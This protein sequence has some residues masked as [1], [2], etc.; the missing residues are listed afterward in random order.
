M[1]VLAVMPAAAATGADADEITV[2]GSSRTDFLYLREPP[3]GLEGLLEDGSTN[4]D[5]WFDTRAFYRNWEGSVRLRVHETAGIRGESSTEEIDRR[6]LAYVGP[7]VEVL[8]GHFYQTL[9]NGL[10][11]RAMEQ[12]FVT[13]NHVDRAFNLDRSL[14][15]VRVRGERGPVR[16]TLLSGTPRR[17]EISRVGGAS[18]RESDDLLQG[19][20]AVVSAGNHVE[21]G[22]GYLMAEL[23][24][25]VGAELVRRPEDLVSYRGRVQWQGMTGE[26]EVAEKR[27]RRGFVPDGHA[28]VVRLNGALGFVGWSLEGKR[29]RDFAFLHNQPPTLVRTHES[30][31]LNRET[32][33]LLP[34]DER[35]LQAEVL[36]A[37]DVFT[38]F[39]V[40]VALAEGEDLPGRE[41]REVYTEARTEREGLGAGR[42][43]LDW[44]RDETKV[45][46]NRWTAALELETFLD[47]LNSVILDLELQAEETV[48][49]E[50][51]RQLLQLGV[52][53]A[54][55][56]TVTVTGEHTN[57]RSRPK[58]DWV[59][60][61]LDLRLSEM[62]D[63][64]VGYG[65]RP[66]GIVCSGGFCFE[67]PEF[68]GAEVR[69]L[70]RF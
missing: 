24:D 1:M 21:L 50:V 49:R 42:L 28:L 19:G 51:T 13:L 22:F 14:D 54:G 39:L 45:V 55:V 62:F 29:Y 48:S 61:S 23:A 41:Y 38:T 5:V 12:R 20:E 30:V 11:L 52:S 68:D 64:T 46:E 25:S 35:G 66:A 7:D 65:S 32:H 67:S 10:I 26:V 43:A 33:V 70:S 47:D 6:H 4:L 31:L 58:H 18:D 37:P 63:L 34:D 57:N 17:E 40:N 3:A 15:G 16:L 9:G 59:F 44:A 69:L 36:A 2:T 8:A 53:H 56:W 27:P 60:A